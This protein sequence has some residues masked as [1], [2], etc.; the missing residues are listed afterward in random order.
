MYSL[1]TKNMTKQ[2]CKRLITLLPLVT[3]LLTGCPKKGNNNNGGNGEKHDERTGTVSFEVWH[4]NDI[5][6]QVMEE[7]G[8]PGI[9]KLMTFLKEKGQ[10]ENTLLLDQGDTWQGSIYSNYNHGNLI[11]DVMNYVQY[12]A[13]TIGNHD[14]DWGVQKIIDNKNRSYQDYSTPVLAGNLYD[15][16][17]DTKVVGTTQ[18]SDVGAKSV[19]YTLENGLK[20]GVLGCIGADQM[21]DISSVFMRNYAFTNHIDF[22][23]A[24]ATHL[25]NDEH[26]DV[27][28]CSIHSGQATVLGNGLNNYVDLV[29]CGHTHQNETATEGNLYYSQCYSNTG[30]LGHVKLKYNFDTKKVTSTSVESI[31]GYQLASM[32][33]SVDPTIQSI[34]TGYN[35]ECSAAANTVVASNVVTDFTKKN[36]FPKLMCKA[37]Y[38]QAVSEGYTNLV[39][40]YV[41][42]GRDD[43]GTGSWTYA[44]L[45]DVFPFDNEVMIAD[46][47]GSELISQCDHGNYRYVNPSA[48]KTIQLNGTYKIAVLDFLYYH[49]DSESREYNYFSQTGGTSSLKLSKNYR[50]ILRDWLI[51]NGYSTGK[52]LDYSD[53][54]TSEYASYQFSY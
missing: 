11:T 26:C 13:R 48:N 20:V 46:I 36:G 12:D 22:I 18:Q 8:H 47:T 15:F 40:S 7:S 16:N 34:M 24:E 3:L 19:T 35:N 21:K 49:T 52:A 25:R 1:E 2:N 17:F 51:S 28:I 41:N 42:Q 23:K 27:V 39:L 29:L 14:F 31:T 9:G 33:E 4:T 10:N 38:D 45:Y 44:D 6:G 54:N 43:K 5:H 30:S 32:V 53:F 37:I 50:E